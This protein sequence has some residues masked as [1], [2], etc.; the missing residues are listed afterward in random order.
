MSRSARIKIPCST[1]SE[2]VPEPRQALRLAGFSLFNQTQGDICAASPYN[3]SMKYLSTRGANP[4]ATFLD[5]L[6][7]GLAPD[8]G[9][10]VPESWSSLPK[11]SGKESYTEIAAQVI[12]PYTDGDLSRP[13]LFALLED[14]YNDKVFMGGHPAPL[15]P[16]DEH[17]FLMELFHGPTLAFK[18]VALQLLGRLFDFAL[19]KSGQHLT[20]IGAT[21]G[22]TGS[23]AIEAC[24]GRENITVYILHPHGR[25]SEVQ[26]RQMTTVLAKNIHNIAIEGTFD[27]CQAIV[28]Q[29]F[30]DPDLRAQKT[31]SAINSINWARI[32]AQTVYYTWAAAQFDKPVA[33]AVPTGNFGNVYAAYVA[34]RMGANVGSLV[35]GSNRNDILTR[36]FANGTMKLEPVIPSLSPSMDIQISS[37]FERYLWDLLGRDAAHLSSLM[38]KFKTSGSFTLDTDLMAKARQDFLAYRCDDEETLRIIDRMYADYGQIIDPHTAV[39]VKAMLRARAEKRVDPSTPFVALACAHPAKFPAA[40]KR[41]CDITPHLPPHLADLMSRPERLSVLPNNFSAVKSLILES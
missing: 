27:D 24:K 33:F 9:L 32:I 3:S 19:R 38:D 26:R 36:F 8:G 34:K 5:V 25:P 30:G 20:I 14:T 11:F 16:L 21:S 31:L 4:P 13:E 7:S 22:D 12:G 39:G 40:I 6:M 17:S 37:N 28:K 35:V 10:F 1:S 29:A 41:A 18:D 15:S 2:I 23:A